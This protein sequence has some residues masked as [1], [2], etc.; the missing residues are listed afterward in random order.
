MK[1]EQKIMRK[2]L[3]RGKTKI[4]KWVKGDYHTYSEKGDTDNYIG[5]SSNE[6]D[7][8]IVIPETVGQFTGLIDKNRVDIFEGDICESKEIDLKFVVKWHNE[9]SGYGAFKDGE[10]VPFSWFSENKDIE[11]IGNFYDNP[12]LLN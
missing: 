4:G 7:P 6:S 10:T 1:N 5:I 2:I 12:E 3:F 8:F 9:M 11:I